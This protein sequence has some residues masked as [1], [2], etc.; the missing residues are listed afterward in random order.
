M[1]WYAAMHLNPTP[2]T[3]QILWNTFGIAV[4]H[5]SHVLTRKN[6][7]ISSFVFTRYVSLSLSSSIETFPHSKTH[8]PETFWISYYYYLFF[9]LSLSLSLN[10]LLCNLE[11]LTPPLPFFSC[12]NL[13]P[14]LFSFILGWGFIVTCPETYRPLI[15]IPFLVFRVFYGYS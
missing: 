6:W 10:I 2:P 4:H 1:L 5:S 8:K 12:T 14:L 3:L 9:S 13:H 15:L 11:P 7:Q